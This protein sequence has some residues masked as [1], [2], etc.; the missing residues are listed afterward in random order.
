MKVK[1]VKHFLTS[2]KEMSG[3]TI[4]LLDKMETKAK[5]VKKL[6]DGALVEALMQVPITAALQG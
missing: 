6:I 2:M 3:I 4:F 1:F 5:E